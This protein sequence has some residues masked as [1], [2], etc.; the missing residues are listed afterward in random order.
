MARFSFLRGDTEC[1]IDIELREFI[2]NHFAGYNKDILY[3]NEAMNIIEAVLPQSI[4]EEEI[5]ERIKRKKKTVQRIFIKAFGVN[6][7]QLIA[8][9]R[10]YCSLILLSEARLD[11]TETAIKLNYSDLSS[12]DRD[13]KKVLGITPC[14][15]K[16]ELKNTDPDCLYRRYY[17]KRKLS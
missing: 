17:R 14:K 8:A 12:M 10:I 11:I 7:K 4:S 9:Y 13:F 5:A 16:A 2:D 15:V 6:Y 3:L 1:N